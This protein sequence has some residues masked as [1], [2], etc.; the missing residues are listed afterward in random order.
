VP[1]NRLDEAL[2]EYK[3]ALQLDPVSAIVYSNLAR[4]L[5]IARR[6]HEAEQQYQRAFELEPDFPNAHFGMAEVY[7]VEGKYREAWGEIIRFHP[8]L[9]PPNVTLPTGKDGYWRTQLAAAL[10]LAT[11]VYVP[12]LE[13]SR[14]YAALGD[15]DKAFEWLQKGYEEPDDLLPYF[16]RGPAYDN[17]RSDPRYV[18]FMHRMGLPP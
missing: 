16:I 6:Y 10:Q 14:C 17:L 5:F 4:T 15:K 3:T 1:M 2:A 11:R 7:E 18:G 8:E 9:S 12:S 13:V